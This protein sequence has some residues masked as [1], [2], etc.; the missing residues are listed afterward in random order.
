MAT[1]YSIQNSFHQENLVLRCYKIKVQKNY[2]PSFKCYDLPIHAIKNSKSIFTYCSSS[3]QQGLAIIS[4]KESLCILY[5]IGKINKYSFE[6]LFEKFSHGSLGV[7]RDI[8]KLPCMGNL[9][10]LLLI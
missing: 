9:M 4:A 3:L 1:F 10:S 8:I 2:L 6:A 5:A 7:N